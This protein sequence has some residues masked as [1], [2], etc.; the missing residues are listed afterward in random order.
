MKKT[1]ANWFASADYDIQTAEAMLKSQRYLYVV[2]M[3]HLAI[4]KTLKALYSDDFPVSAADR[5]LV[6]AENQKGDAMAEQRSTPD[7]E[8]KA[9][10]RELEHLRIRPERVALFG[11]WAMGHQHDGSDIDLILISRDFKRKGLRRRLEL[12]GVAAARALVPVQALGYTP[13][14]VENRVSGG[15]LD[16]ILTGEV[17]TVVT[18]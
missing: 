12:L 15:F 13:E 8:I 16:D 14:E 6:S 11:S 17:V 18:E 9:F 1:T 2:F 3:C 7:G 4:E 10:C 5:G